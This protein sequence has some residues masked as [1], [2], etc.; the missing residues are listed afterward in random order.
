MYMYASECLA[1]NAAKQLEEIEKKERKIMRR[2][3]GPKHE[4]E[5]WKLRSN[6]E[7]YDKIEKIGDSMRKRRVQYYGHLERMEGSRL[8]KKLFDYFD[9]TPKTKL[10]WFCETKKDLREMD[11]P[12]QVTSDRKQFREKVKKFSKFKEREKKKKTAFHLSRVPPG[13]MK[14]RKNTARG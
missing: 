1:L 4:N 7:I 14:G 11:I 10:T 9:K 8:T 12:L 2:I 13:Q 5:I 3:L 6:K